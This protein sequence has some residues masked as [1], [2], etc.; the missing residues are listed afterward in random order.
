MAIKINLHFIRD[1]LIRYFYLHLG[2]KS[3]N[4]IYQLYINERLYHIDNNKL[5]IPSA[6][7]L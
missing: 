7:L 5:K 2:E 1:E 3:I 4:I 6:T